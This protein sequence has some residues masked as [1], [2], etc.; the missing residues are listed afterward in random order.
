M[1][2]LTLK[3]FRLIAKSRNIENYQNISKAQ[4]I[5]I[6]TTPQ[7]SKPTPHLSKSTP[8]LSKPTPQ[9]LKPIPNIK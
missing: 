8:Q 6:I 5:N 3:K 1:L 7:L 4:L 9:P 2:N